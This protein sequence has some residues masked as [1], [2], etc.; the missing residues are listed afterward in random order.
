MTKIIRFDLDCWYTSSSST[1][2]D[3]DKPV[4]NTKIIVGNRDRQDIKNELIRKQLLKRKSK[5]QQNKSKKVSYNETLF[6]SKFI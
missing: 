2:I 1:F 3:D 5:N 4:M 6:Y